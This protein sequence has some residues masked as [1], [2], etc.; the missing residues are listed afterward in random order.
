MAD[1]LTAA[2]LAES[3]AA[4]VDIDVAALLAQIQALQARVDDMSR[5]AGIPADPIEAGIHDL[6][7][8]VYARAY[9]NPG[10]VFTELT[11]AVD[12]LQS[13]PASSDVELCRAVLDGMPRFEG[14][15]YIKELATNL[16]KLVLKG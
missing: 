5:A 8:H 7:N 3:G 16:Y 12:A 10:M 2:S 1:E 14:D 4:P 9:G 11:S 6:R 15:E 13:P